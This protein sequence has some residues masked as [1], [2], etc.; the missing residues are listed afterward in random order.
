MLYE[1][2]TTAASPKNDHSH[3]LS[4]ASAHLSPTVNVERLEFPMT[5]DR[6][7]LQD[8]WEIV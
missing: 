4:I 6:A 8:A 7:V 1:V 2:I 5:R 3:A